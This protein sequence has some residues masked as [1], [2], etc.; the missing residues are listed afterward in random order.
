MSLV[1]LSEAKYPFAWIFRYAQNDKNPAVAVSPL[2]KK[3]LRF[4]LD[5]LA[6]FL[7]CRFAL[8]MYKTARLLPYLVIL[9]EAKY[10]QNQSMDSS[11]AAQNDKNLAFAVRLFF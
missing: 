9:S 6:R 11:P 4:W 7:P 1:I 10:P 8:I 3:A 5:F 2:F